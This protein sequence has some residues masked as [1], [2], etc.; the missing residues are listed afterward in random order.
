MSSE[1]WGGINSSLMCFTLLHPNQDIAQIEN[2]LISLVTKHRPKS[3]NVHR[4]KLQPLDDIHFNDAY[5]GINVNLLWIFS[6]IGFFLIAVGCINFINISTAQAFTRSKEIG[7]RKVLG[8]LKEHLFWQFIAET[9]IISLSAMVIGLVIAAIAL[10]SFNTLFELNLSIQSLLEFKVIGFMILILLLVTFFAGSYPGILLARILPTLAL[11]GKLTEKDTGG[12]QTR[13]I[14]VTAQFTISIVLIVATVIVG[15][16]IN[17][18]VHADLG[19]EKDAIIMVEIPEEIEHIKIEG[20][21][22]RITKLSG[23]NSMTACLAS[24]GAAYN[25]WGTGIKYNNRAEPE[26]FSISAK[27]A[28]TDYI[29]T[30]GLDLVAG[31]NFFPSDSVTEVVVNEKL[32][33]K[34]GLASSE[35]LLGKRIEVNGGDTKATIVGVVADFHDQ[36]F[37]KEIRPIFIAP[38]TSGYV[39]FAIKIQGKNAEPTL[40]EV[41]KL[42]Q[43]VFPNYNYEFTFM[44]ER[45]AEQYEDEQ[46]FL[47]MSKLFSGLAIFISCLGMYGL[48]SFFV[49]QRKKEIGIRKV[50]GGK[51]SDILLLFTQDFFKLIFIAGFIATPLAWYFMNNWLENYKYRV[52]IDW[53]VFVLAIGAIIVITMITISYQAIKAALQNPVKS[54]RTE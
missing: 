9:G 52:T 13:K 43:D 12:K 40:A 7:I 46:R 25:N 14:L 17:Y 5:G 34:L 2:T 6:L 1:S 38:Q 53:W 44:D 49:A 41:K 35:E 23:V 24:P 47:S 19:F 8:G 16:Q 10:P 22:E 30:F 11:K 18:A 54:L 48:I 28:D 37:Q 27:L 3:K 32:A 50:L 39:N 31:R 51:I 15:K 26:E 4:Y 29:T 42:W 36:N 20:L 21:K 33:Q 45:V